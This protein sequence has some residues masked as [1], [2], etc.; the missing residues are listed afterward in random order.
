MAQGVYLLRCK[1]DNSVYVG[2]SSDLTKREQYHFQNLRNGRHEC[3]TLQ[4]SWLFYGEDSFE[5][6]IIDGRDRFDKQDRI[7]KEDFWIK[8]FR[9]DPDVKL[10]N[11]YL[12]TE[13]PQQ[14]C[15]KTLETR[16]RI[17]KAKRGKEPHNK[18]P[19][20]PELLKDIENGISYKEFEAKYGKSR[21]TLKRIKKE[22]FY[23]EKRVRIR[24]P[25]LYLD[26]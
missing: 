6:K 18:F 21:N 3:A 19:A 11:Q 23:G 4:T 14:G 5:F 8:H 25:E 2:Q 24:H 17:S 13:H 7:A 26:S 12:S 9:K 15:M 22:Y 10:H 1:G 16:K 20:T